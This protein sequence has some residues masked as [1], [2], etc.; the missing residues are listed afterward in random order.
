M[1]NRFVSN[2]TGISINGALGTGNVAR[3][4]AIIGSTSGNG[5]R[6]DRAVA[7]DAQNNWW[8]CNYG[9]GAGGSGCVGT[10]NG[11]GGTSV[12]LLD[13]NP[14]LRLTT[15]AASSP[16]LVGGTSAITS[17]LTTN[18]DNVT[19]GGGSIPNFMTAS[20]VGTFGTVVSPNTF[21]AG[22]TGT[23]FTATSQ[24]VGG[25]DTTVDGQTVSAPITVYNATCSAVTT[26]NV[27]TLTGVGIS[28]PVNTDLMTGR[29]AISADFVFNYN[30]A[31]L[32]PKVAAVLAG[33]VAGGGAVITFRTPTSPIP[34][35]AGTVIVSVVNS[36]GF[37]GSGALVTMEFDVIGPIGST[38]PLGI[39]PISGF[40]SSQLFNGGYLQCNTVTTGT[41]TVISGTVSGTVTYAHNP[42]V[43]PVRGVL[44]DAPGSP[45]VSDI[46]DAAGLYSMDGFGPGSYTLTP[47]K[48]AYP[49]GTSIPA[50][51][52]FA[53]DATAI[54]QHVVGL[55]PITNPTQL[56]AAKVSGV[57][58]P[59]LSSFDAALISQWIVAI[60][61]PIN[62][63]G[64]WKFTNTSEFLGVVTANQT[65]N[66]T[67][68]LMGDVNGSWSNMVG[69]RPALTEPTERSVLPS[70]TSMEAEKG[71]EIIVP[72][73]IDNLGGKSVGSYQFDI[74][75]DP[76]VIEPVTTAADVMGTQSESLTIIS[77][78]PEPG[79]LKVAAYGALPASG[80]GVYVN[81]KFRTIGAVGS[82][83]QVT[84]SEF[85]FNN[86]S[87][88]V[89][90]KGGRVSVTRESN[91]TGIKG[92]VIS[93]L[94]QPVANAKVILT[95][96]DGTTRTTVTGSL[97]SYE[98]GGL[99]TGETYTVTVQAKR[100]T[101]EPRSVSVTGTTVDLDMIA[102]Q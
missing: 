68:L 60:P 82:T 22:V 73:R 1:G 49:V 78:S 54:V 86:G 14:W 99:A 46:T 26:D 55:V 32:T 85:R 40:T 76:T 94:G 39:S 20:F 98:F 58:T 57:V 91:D 95:A 25:V 62:Q 37:T 9:P 45:N 80:D 70:I 51:G 84:I 83:T 6:N 19:P 35:P 7:F 18:S 29:G 33:P 4:N 69:S 64:Q 3:F 61:S 13:A 34:S 97:G 75:F 21:T 38:S 5:I 41:L 2:V 48:T 30:N 67:G 71:R 90:A 8:G 43:L 72:F 63:T 16:I 12:G 79:L 102:R 88:E 36:G 81:L 101:F 10:P 23:T 27:D 66:F 28:I 56:A 24:G 53:D 93:A 44:L 92:R 17:L 31:V 65:H 42:G 96:T 47:S 59:A 87:D 77:N 50:H 15:S 89:F 74:E 11:I 100:F 52:I